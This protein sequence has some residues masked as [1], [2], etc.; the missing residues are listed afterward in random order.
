MRCCVRI[1]PRVMVMLFLTVGIVVT[2]VIYALEEVG[3][4]WP[5]LT[6]QPLWLLGLVGMATFPVGCAFEACRQLLVRKLSGK[7]PK[8]S[9][10]DFEDK[11]CIYWMFWHMIPCVATIEV[12][13]LIAPSNPYFIIVAGTGYSLGWLIVMLRAL[14]MSERKNP[15]VC[16]L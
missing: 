2:F 13:D 10:F 3:S 15:G 8:E 1:W 6:E 9:P 11:L 4:W 5:K 7:S 14:G 16:H 12:V